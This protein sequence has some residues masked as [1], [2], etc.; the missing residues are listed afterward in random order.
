MMWALFGGKT[1]FKVL[2]K[3]AGDI[4][5]KRKKLTALA[6]LLMVSFSLPGQTTNQPPA[7]DKLIAEKFGSVWVQDNGGRIKPL[8]SLHQEIVVK[9]V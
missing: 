3:K 6:I 5:G 8:N 4:Y 9:L 1:R 2:M 7:P